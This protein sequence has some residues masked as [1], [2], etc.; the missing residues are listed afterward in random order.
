MFSFI[1]SCK[2]YDPCFGYEI[3]VIM[4][5]G[6]RRMYQE[7]ENVF[8]YLTVMNENYI[9]PAMPEGVEENIIKGMYLFKE[10]SKKSDLRVQ[11]LGS[12]AILRE[13][14]AGAEILEQQFQ[15]IADVWSVTSFSELRRDILS[16]EHYNRFHLDKDQKQ[17]HVMQCLK[18]RQGPVIAATDYLKL[19]ADQI[20][21]AIKQPYYVLGTDGFGRSDTRAFLRTFFEVD[22]KHI[23]YTALKALMDE[24][25]LEK[26]YLNDALKKLQI[27]PNKPEPKTL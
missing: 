1:P 22:A 18:D 25:K 24:G 19:F 3:A 2:T 11:L 26:S 16:V 14:L 21:V 9:H 23:A 27:D 20:R 8:Y 4:Q 12:G 7:E 17:S 13:V 5:D 10:N 6:L 15:V